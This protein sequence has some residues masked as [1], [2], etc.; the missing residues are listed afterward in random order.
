MGSFLNFLFFV[1]SSLSLVLDL[2]LQAHNHLYICFSPVPKSNL[3]NLTSVIRCL[4]RV[5]A[6]TSNPFVL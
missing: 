1:C 3:T 5:G 4:C 2:I 6:V